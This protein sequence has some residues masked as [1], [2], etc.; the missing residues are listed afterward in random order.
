MQKKY[1]LLIYNI[2]YGTG[3]GWKFHIPFPFI[4]FLKRTRKNIAK[5]AEF[6]K[7][8][9]L[10]IVGLVEVDEGSY[11]HYGENQAEFIAQKLGLQVNYN[12]KYKIGS[13]TGIIPLMSKQGNAFLTKD[14]IKNK[15]I[16]FFDSGIKRV[17]IELE[18]EEVVLFLLHL[19]LT[20]RSRQCQLNSLFNLMQKVNKPIIIAGD[21][22][23]LSGNKEIEVFLAT[24]GLKSMNIENSFTYPSIRPKKQLDFILYSSGIN[25]HDFKILEKATFSDHLPIYCEFSV[26]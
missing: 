21:L 8:Y 19:S 14:V 7:K 11:R 12:S 15:K 1:K 9:N 4:G 6:L 26:K 23:M 18:L 10:D 25:V 2:R 13:R 22:N 17:A 3:R 16:H 24:T 5:I 20:N